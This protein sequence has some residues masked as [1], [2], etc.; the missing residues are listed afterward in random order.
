MFLPCVDKASFLEFS[1][2]PTRERKGRFILGAQ[3]CIGIV[4]LNGLFMVS[5]RNSS[6]AV[7]HVGWKWAWHTDSRA[8]CSLGMPCAC[9]PSPAPAQW[10]GSSYQV[11]EPSGSSCPSL[12]TVTLCQLVSRDAVVVLAFQCFSFPPV[13]KVPTR[14]LSREEKEMVFLSTRVLGNPSVSS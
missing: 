9:R 10:P 7:F 12:C 3:Q 2:G 1:A 5:K 4:H 11:Q 13:S 14:S 8:A 6:G